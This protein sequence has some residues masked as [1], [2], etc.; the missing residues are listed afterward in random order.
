[1]KSKKIKFVTLKYYLQALA[2]L[3]LSP[4]KLFNIWDEAPG[5]LSCVG[6]FSPFLKFNEIS[7]YG[8]DVT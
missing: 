5:C 1:M 6:P 3:G 8:Y 4:P 2:D 7:T